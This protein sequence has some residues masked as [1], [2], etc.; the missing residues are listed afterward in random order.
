MIRRWLVLLLLS[1]CALQPVAPLPR[2]VQ[3]ETASFAMNGRISVKHNGSRDSAGL[4]WMHQ[5]QTDEILLL[6]PLGQTAARIYR[7]AKEA[8]LDED[9]KHYSDTDVESLM[10]QVLGW[11]LQLDGLHH[12]VLGLADGR[13]A[14]VER[15]ELGRLTVLHQD[16]WEVRY[17]KYADNKAD[18]LPAR[19]QLSRENLQLTLLID[20]WEWNIK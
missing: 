5:A 19:M 13:D 7:D 12:W 17:L 20:E 10:M 3:S 1:G 6:T 8:T 2:P 4:R 11:R 14:L 9:D 16:G 18:S 15:D